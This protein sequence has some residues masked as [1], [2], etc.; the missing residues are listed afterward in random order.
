MPVA[1]VPVAELTARRAP[2][3]EHEA[4]RASAGSTCWYVQVPHTQGYADPVDGAIGLLRGATGS[5]RDT[6][7]VSVDAYGGSS[8]AS[9]RHSPMWA[10][11]RASRSVRPRRYASARA[12]G[13][14][15]EIEVPPECIE[16]TLLA[17]SR[18]ARHEQREARRVVRAEVDR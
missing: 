6:M 11:A 3:T 12:S 13:C 5:S 7:S 14:K 9:A 2:Q 17:P 4:R 16:R 10:S 18:F 15:P 8:G 1:A